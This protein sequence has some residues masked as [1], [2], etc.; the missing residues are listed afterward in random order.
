MN[1]ISYRGAILAASAAILLGAT[2]PGLTDQIRINIGS[3]QPEGVLTNRVFKSFFMKT[4]AD[5]VEAETDHSISWTEAWGGSV[6]KPGECGAALRDGLL[7][8]AEVTTIYEPRMIQYGIVSGYVPFASGEPKVVA[9]AMQ[10]LID[11]VPAYKDYAREKNNWEF[12]TFA[13]QADYGILTTFTWDNLSDLAGHRIAGGSSSLE[14]IRASGATPVEGSFP[15]AYTAMQSGV[16]EGWYLPVAT[17]LPLKLHEVAK[18]YTQIGVG[19]SAF[20]QYFANHDFF[21]ALPDEV[22]AIMKEVAAD[23][24]G[25]VTAEIEKSAVATIEEM[26]KAG[27]R[28]H[29][30]PD[31]QRTEWVNKLPNIPKRMADEINAKGQPGEVVEG[32][33]KAMK[34]SGHQFPRDW[35]K[36]LN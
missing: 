13:A 2:A 22:Q 5:R 16:Y 34:A 33:I 21:E 4:F 18:Q 20:S 30:V 26:R 32:Y 31:E 23:Y 6:C 1:M 9:Q 14:I 7:D 3:S 29:A 12:L 24:T 10:T 28:I 25:V 17:V 8:I 27:V 15:E 36:E 35:E 11:T 19:G